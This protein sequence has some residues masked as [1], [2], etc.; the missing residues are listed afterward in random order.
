ML[1]TKA[2]I[3]SIVWPSVIA[4][5]LTLTACN[6]NAPVVDAESTDTADNIDDANELNDG[7]DA[8][9][10]SSE[11]TPAIG[12]ESAE[13]EMITTLSNYR[14]TLNAATD[15]SNQPINA[16][17]P[18]KKQVTLNFNPQGNQTLNY[19][20]GCNTM[21]ATFKLQANSLI[22][23][24]SMSTKMSCGELD[25]AENLLNELMQG[26]SELTLES[27][28]NRTESPLLTQVTNEASTLV[29]SGRLTPQAKY[30]SRG[31]TIFWEVAAESQPCQD[32]NT[33]MCLQVR[34]I[35]YDEQGL[36]TSEGK[37][38]E[39]A[40]SID[41][42]QHDGKHNEVLRLQRFKTDTDTVLV[43]NVD[44]NFAYV[45]DTVIESRVVE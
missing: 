1:T 27:T 22:T 26:E 25:A 8:A 38:V 14:W 11:A 29:W 4:A 43:D 41:G 6:D 5:I 34:P 3:K 28:D 31:E 17:L 7:V 42:Y 23:E 18:I 9:A 39:F 20:V 37:Y 45:L 44:S 2:N 30:N 33:Q 35:S 10:A 32:N 16:L 24:E 40:G 36:K 21:S 12:A 13:E 19:S 15:E